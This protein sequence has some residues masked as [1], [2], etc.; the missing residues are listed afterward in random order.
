MNKF[1]YYIYDKGHMNTIIK[2]NM[3]AMES[4]KTA[5]QTI[6]TSTSVQA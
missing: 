1:L 2:A 6:N 3:L 4:E 5:G